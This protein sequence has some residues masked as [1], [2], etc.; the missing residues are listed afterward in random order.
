MRARTILVA[1]L[2]VALANPASAKCAYHAEVFAEVT[3]QTCIAVQFTAGNSKYN[4]QFPD[5]GPEPMFRAGETLSGTLLTVSVK[6][7]R[8]AWP[9]NTP[10]VVNGARLWAKGDVRS[11]FVQKGPSE[12]CPEVLPIDATVQTQPTCCDTIPGGWECLL[13]STTPLVTLS[14][15]KARK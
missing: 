2:G 15:P 4:Y 11:V 7:S 14:T 3:V 5:S 8:F 12:V 1:A 13:P 10:H 9:E 6:S